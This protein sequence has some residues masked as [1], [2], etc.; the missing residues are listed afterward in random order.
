M[1]KK[2]KLYLVVYKNYVHLQTFT[3]RVCICSLKDLKLDR[4]LRQADVA[5]LAR[6]SDL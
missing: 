1:R 4:I 6:A 3:D 5:Q 2:A